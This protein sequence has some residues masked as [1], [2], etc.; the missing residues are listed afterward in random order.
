VKRVARITGADI[1]LGN[2]VYGRA[3][4]G[5]PDAEAC[6]LALAETRGVMTESKQGP[7]AVGS[8]SAGP[9]PVG[10][11]ASAAPHDPRDRARR[12]LRENGGCC[13]EDM[14]HFEMCLP[15]V[16]SAWDHVACTHAMYRLTAKSM[17]AVNDRLPEGQHLYM[18]A[19]NSDGH[20]H[21]YGA[22]L[23]FL[24]TR[25][26]FDDIFLRK[27]HYLAF[28]A[29][30]QSSAICITGQGKVGS[31]NGRP[32]VPYQLSQRADYFEVLE[33]IQTTCNRPIVNRPDEPLCGTANDSS[34]GRRPDG[35]LARL[36]CIFFDSN[37]CQSA[38]LL[39]VGTMQIILSMI[40]AGEVPAALMLDDAVRA[41]GEWSHDP[42]LRAT[43]K[44]ADGR[45]RTAVEMQR[46]FFEEASCAGQS[47][48]FE[49]IVPRADEILRLWGDT[50]EKLEARDFEALA[51]H[52]D[53]VLKKRIIERHLDSDTD[54]DWDSEDA[55]Y[56]D[57]IYASIDP[58][59]GLYLAHE[60]DGLT[61]RVCSEERIEHFMAEPPEDTRAWAR[62]MILRRVREER[63]VS[64]DWDGIVVDGVGDRH[65]RIAL[66]D[67]RCS[68]RNLDGS[69]EHGGLNHEHK[70]QT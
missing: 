56:L 16:F 13:Y 37:L 68:G 1:E 31:E 5:N 62:S 60:R 15:E 30:F 61:D 39:K 36:H 65:M 28:L 4:S 45:R 6:R 25:R 55:V 22:H 18:L 59:D 64:V 12:Y 3:D 43:A 66:D 20:S 67:P 49:G 7:Y 69:T 58:A 29:A 63:I 50:L 54:L 14:H 21:S 44:L 47:G 70:T 40:E 46:M 52:L 8:Y 34:A 48:M 17:A 2:F 32:W 35:S 10:V 51:A 27:P 24:I 53:W 41:V 9:S 11:G 57:H 33:G 23:N 42:S 19:N 26:T 38:M